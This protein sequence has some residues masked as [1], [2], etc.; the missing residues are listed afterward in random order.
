MVTVPT[1]FHGRVAVLPV[2][3]IVA[4]SRKANSDS[5]SADVCYEIPNQATSATVG[6]RFGRAAPRT[7]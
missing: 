3:A 7:H 1:M 5:I 4:P 6:A 2:V